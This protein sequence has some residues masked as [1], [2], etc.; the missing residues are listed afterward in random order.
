MQVVASERLADEGELRRANAAGEF[1]PEYLPRMD[2]ATGAV[3]GFEARLRWN[4]PVRG[5]PRVEQFALAADDS[6][7]IV[8]LGWLLVAQACLYAASLHRSWPETA[9]RDVSI[10]LY[11]QQLRDPRLMDDLRQI[12][13]STA[14]E[15][16]RRTLTVDSSTVLEDRE[17]TSVIMFEV[18][19]LG[20]RCGLAGIGV[21]YTSVANL[22]DRPIDWITIDRSLVA[23]IGLSDEYAATVGAVRDMARALGV[24][25]LTDRVEAAGRVTGPRAF[26]SDRVQGSNV[27]GGWSVDAFAPHFRAGIELPTPRADEE[28]AT[29]V[30][31]G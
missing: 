10:Q 1:T 27:S 12:L 25:L 14:M 17:G 5:L 3:V 26:G 16:S 2:L 9:P 8:P 4:P 29:A 22:A 28:S 19:A 11:P 24:G 21:G 31:A 6:G 18:R 15:P 13:K 23:K 30:A 20:A 7:T